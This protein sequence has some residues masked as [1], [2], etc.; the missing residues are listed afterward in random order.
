[1]IHE[2]NTLYAEGNKVLYVEKVNLITKQ[3]SYGSVMFP[4]NGTLQTI[5]TTPEDVIE[6]YLVTVDGVE[7][8]VQADSYNELV[9][10]L[11]RIKYNLD[12]ELALIANMRV[13][14]EQYSQEDK[15]FQ[16][17]RTYCKELA[18]KLINE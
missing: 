6:C 5:T 16:E 10:A 17:W 14:P 1:M 7:Y 13:N 15:V 9:T 12:E 8:K 3:Y 18:K 2:N 11:I 4:I